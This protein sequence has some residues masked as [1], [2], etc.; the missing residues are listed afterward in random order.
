MQVTV[1]STQQSKEKDK[2]QEREAEARE[3]RY[4]K[5]LI[6]LLE[7]IAMMNQNRVPQSIEN[8]NESALSL[9]NLT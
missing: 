7:R 3:E 5:N 6:Q 9:S 8:T 1:N 2:Q 4:Q